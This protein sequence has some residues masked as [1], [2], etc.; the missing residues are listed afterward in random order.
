MTAPG[1]RAEPGDQLRERERL[2]QVV[3]GAAAEARD[4]V[5]DRA[6]GGEHEDAR[7]HA[8]DELSADVVPVQHGKVPVEHDDVVVVHEGAVEPGGA[9]K[10]GV[11]RHA[12]HPQARGDRLGEL[13]VVLDHKHAH[14]SLPSRCHCSTRSLARG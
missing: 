7:P 5:L 6:G 14:E 9:V 8:G 10:R 13:A 3:V 11:D 12:F 1:E 2:G 4:A